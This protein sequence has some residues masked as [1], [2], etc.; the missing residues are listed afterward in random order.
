MRGS[1]STGGQV[2]YPLVLL[3]YSQCIKRNPHQKG[4]IGKKA[5]L[6]YPYRVGKFLF[7]T[8]LCLKQTKRM[9]M[10]MY[11]LEQGGRKDYLFIYLLRRRFE[12]TEC[13][14]G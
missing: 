2:T 3:C 6:N 5:R 10:A 7:C 12:I 14:F 11:L 8:N 4:K 13:L 9:L 1:S